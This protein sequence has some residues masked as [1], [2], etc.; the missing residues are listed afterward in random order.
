[1][2]E[3]YLE[4]DIDDTLCAL[5][6]YDSDELSFVANPN[7]AGGKQVET[8]RESFTEYKED[9]VGGQQ[10]LKRN[11]M[12]KSKQQFLLFINYFYL[13][14]QF[15]HFFLFAVKSNSFCFF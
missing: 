5:M 2:A 14:S 11:E 13:C 4:T 9:K 10:E 6:D 12:C 3:A 1:M 7:E 15:C 8:F